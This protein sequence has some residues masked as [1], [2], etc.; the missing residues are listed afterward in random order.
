MSASDAIDQLWRALETQAVALAESYEAAA[1][2]LSSTKALDE[3]EL[4][5][6]TRPAEDMKPIMAAMA[7]ANETL[8]DL[9]GLVRAH[10]RKTM[11]GLVADALEG[12]A[13]PY[14]QSDPEWDVFSVA[15]RIVYGVDG[16]ADTRSVYDIVEDPLARAAEVLGLFNAEE[17]L[18]LFGASWA[19]GHTTA[20]KAE[21]LRAY[22]RGLY[23]TL[24]TIEHEGGND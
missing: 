6:I 21:F 22:A 23:V 4:S 15:L 20:A 16:L 14:D 9:I 19:S 17:K 2:G 7:A 12:G 11:M 13:V 18:A 24:E 8:E 3:L 5:E 10:R 1:V